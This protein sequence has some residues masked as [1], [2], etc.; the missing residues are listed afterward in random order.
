MNYTNKITNF[1]SLT[2]KYINVL[3]QIIDYSV[4]KNILPLKIKLGIDILK[5]YIMDNKIKI[6]QFGIEYL[7][8]NKDYILNFSLN[9]LDDLDNDSD[10]NIS[11]ASLLNNIKETKPNLNL[12]IDTEDKTILNLIIEIKNNSKKLNDYEKTIINGYMQILIMILE[13]IQKIFI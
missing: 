12:N 1:T 3:Y 9:S 13:N 10:D 5:N 8:K 11:R 2:D 6:I 7:L 4:S